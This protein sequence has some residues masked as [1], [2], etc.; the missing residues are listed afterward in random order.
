[1]GGSITGEHG[2]LADFRLSQLG[3][4]RNGL[5][6]KAGLAGNIVAGIGHASLGNVEWTLLLE[7]LVGSLPGIWIGA[8]LTRQPNV[9]AIADTKS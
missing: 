3:D 2:K 7:L 8:K 6:W 5:G 4:R 1:M 9:P